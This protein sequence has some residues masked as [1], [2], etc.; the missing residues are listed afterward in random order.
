VGEEI[1]SVWSFGQQINQ[2]IRVNQIRHRLGWSAVA[3][4]GSLLPQVSLKLLNINIFEGTSA[5]SE[6]SAHALCVIVCPQRLCFRFLLCL[7]PEESSRTLDHNWLLLTCQHIKDTLHLL[8][9][10]IKLD[11]AWFI[12]P[13]S[14]LLL[15]L[16]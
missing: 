11:F 5:A 12:G 6:G 2:D 13:D 4:L 1:E 7:N 15:L 10:V 14:Y 16:V 3:V 9:K 8:K